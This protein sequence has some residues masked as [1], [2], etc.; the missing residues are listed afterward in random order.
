VVSGG[1]IVV[2]GL[3]DS[4]GSGRFAVWG[5]NS[6]GGLDGGFGSG[7]RLIGPSS[8]E[9]EQALGLAVAPDG[10]FV[11]D[12]SASAPFTTPFGIVGRLGGAPIV[13]PNIKAALNVNRS[14]R[15]KDVLKH[16]IKVGVSC[17]QGCSISLTL[18][19]TPAVAQ[20]LHFGRKIRKCRKVHGHRRCTT[21]YAGGALATVRATLSNGSL[22]TF[23]LNNG[24]V[25]RAANAFNTVHL[26]VK[27]SAQ[28]LS[29]HKTSSTSTGITIRK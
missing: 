3:Y 8:G 4:G 10:N 16:G 20:K 23:T 27:V 7:G 24:A 1:E 6:A 2:A 28:S 21:T 19:T 9:A 5:L 18:N 15:R 26:V 12:G 17:N 11:V 25:K 22:K 13:V 14:F 29:T